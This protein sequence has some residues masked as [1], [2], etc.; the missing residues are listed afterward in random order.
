MIQE[1]RGLICPD[2]R[3]LWDSA[4]WGSH[5]GQAEQVERPAGRVT[6]G[7]QR[8]TF[9]VAEWGRQKPHPQE[10]PWEG[11]SLMTIACV[12]EGTRRGPLQGPASS[13]ISHRRQHL[14]P[15]Y[16]QQQGV[17]GALTGRGICRLY[18]PAWR[19]LRLLFLPPF[20][21]LLL[22]G[23]EGT[24]DM[25]NSRLRESERLSRVTEMPTGRQPG[26]R[27]SGQTRGPAGFS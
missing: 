5:P 10:R 1:E 21:Q 11:R 9:F 19:L 7:R 3:P 8:D 13:R 4:S 22:P 16:P 15:I 25:M 18:Q 20:S 23:G 2:G 26:P 6:V 24:S 12:E 27:M 14:P 17:A